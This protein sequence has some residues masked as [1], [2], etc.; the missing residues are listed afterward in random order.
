MSARLVILFTLWSLY[1]AYAIEPDPIYQ[2]TAVRHARPRAA[3]ER[4]DP[5]EDDPKLR[6]VFAAVDAAAERRV[7]NV[8]R[9]DKFIFAFWAEKKAILRDQHHIDWKT[10]SELNPQFTYSDYGQREISKR[11]TLE[12]T[13]VIRRRTSNPITIDRDFEGKVRVWTK[14]SG[15]ESTVYV[16]QLERGEWKIVDVE[17]WLP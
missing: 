17:H 3:G 13:R 4:F 16:V 2:E 1:H 8:K 11:E 14:G 12:I 15:R 10:P 7:A 9:N 5:Q 6:D